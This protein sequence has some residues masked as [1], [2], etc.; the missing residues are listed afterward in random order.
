MR[1]HHVPQTHPLFF[2]E[3]PDL[4]LPSSRCE[5]MTG[6]GQP[7]GDWAIRRSHRLV[8]DS[9]NRLRICSVTLATMQ[10]LFLLPFRGSR[11]RQGRRAEGHSRR[12]VTVGAQEGNLPSGTRLP[13]Q[14]RSLGSGDASLRLARGGCCPRPRAVSGE[15]HVPGARWGEPTTCALPVGGCDVI[16]GV[17]C[18]HFKSLRQLTL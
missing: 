10:P 2:L 5:W 4:V 6:R 3:S 8:R 7:E 12:T 11:S 1:D 14:A 16:G 15:D 13:P 9:P 18:E 17:I